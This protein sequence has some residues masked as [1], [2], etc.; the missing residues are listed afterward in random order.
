[1]TASASTP[2]VDVPEAGEIMQ[3]YLARGTDEAGVTP[4]A[5]VAVGFSTPRHL[6]AL[7]RWEAVP[8]YT[9]LASH[10]PPLEQAYEEIMLHSAVQQ[11]VAPWTLVDR[12]R[13]HEG[14]RI[15]HP[16]CPSALQGLLEWLWMTVGISEWPA[17]IA[18]A[19]TLSNPCSSRRTRPAMGIRLRPFRNRAQS[20]TVVGLPKPVVLLRPVESWSDA[21]WVQELVAGLSDRRP[22]PIEQVFVDQLAPEVD[23]DVE[24]YQVNLGR[25]SVL[26][27]AG[28]ALAPSPPLPP[29]RTTSLV[30]GLH[31]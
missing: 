10:P 3:E 14:A 9:A 28:R 12:Q 16:R 17:G 15:D 31:A 19:T 7:R 5:A 27:S 6:E 21:L 30:V 11:D 18:R 1:M 13:A 8:T 29:T 26:Q 25:R 2:R 24:R 4:G 22:N 23:N 20:I